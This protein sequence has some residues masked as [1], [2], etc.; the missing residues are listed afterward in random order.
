MDFKKS[1]FTHIVLSLLIIAAVSVQGAEF[2]GDILAGYNGGV[3]LQINFRAADFAQGFPLYLQLGMAYSRLDPGSAADA[4][5]IFINDATN[6][7][8]EKSG[9]RWDL[10]FDFLHNVDLFQLQDVWLYVGPRYSMFTGNFVFVGGNEDFDITTS[11]WGLGAGLQSYFPM[12]RKFDFVT[13]AGLDYYF[14][15]ALSGHDTKYSPDGENV[16]ARN[17]YT[18]DDADDA[19]NQPKLQ[20]RFMIGITYH[21]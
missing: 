1:K 12:G 18:F 4:R 5:K 21:F 7:D 14:S 11:Q 15:N 16:N 19:I 17:D 2:T 20:I 3:G 9:W 8:P 10:R 6:G 13:S